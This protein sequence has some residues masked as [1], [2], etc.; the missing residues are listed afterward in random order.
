MTIMN[1]EEIKTEKH[2]LEVRKTNLVLCYRNVGYCITMFYLGCV[3]LLSFSLVISFWLLLF[4]F[5]S[6]YIAKGI[7]YLGAGTAG[8]GAG[9]LV[10]KVPLAR[11]F[12]DDV[13]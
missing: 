2:N 7:T 10:F 5:K 4:G 12:H 11:L 6:E 9:S 13:A 8:L 3:C 1:D